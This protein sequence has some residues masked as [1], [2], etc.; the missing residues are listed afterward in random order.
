[1][2]SYFLQFAGPVNVFLFELVLVSY[3]LQL[4][5]ETKRK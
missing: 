4:E 5:F 2:S 3:V 1:M